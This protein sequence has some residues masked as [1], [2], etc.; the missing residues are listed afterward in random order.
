MSKFL[1]GGAKRFAPHQ[2]A[3]V[4][5]LL[6]P[7]PT[8]LISKQT[9]DAMYY[10]VAESSEE[11]S[12][13]GT[14]E[15]DGMTFLI[16]EVFLF[17]QEVHATQTRLDEESVGG[18]FTELASQPDGVEK[19]ERVRFWGHSHVNMGVTPSG[20]YGRADYGD[21]GQMHS[22]GESCDYMVMGIANKGGAFRFEIFFY[23]L[24]IRV[25]DVGWEIYEPEQADLREQVMAELKAK[26]RTSRTH[27]PFGDKWG[28]D[29]RRAIGRKRDRDE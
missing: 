5:G 9:Y 14:V 19:V 25:Q 10:I 3:P 26:V 20:S 29:N 2:F 8:I 1:R 23:D 15:R 12:W 13:L 17:D 4:V 24:G 7:M 6:G 28:Q 22:F 18:F 16:D 21:L 11:V 27:E